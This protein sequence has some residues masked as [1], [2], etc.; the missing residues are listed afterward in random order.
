[1]CIKTC[2]DCIL[3]WSGGLY[4]LKDH[5]VPCYLNSSSEHSMPSSVSL[6]PPPPPSEE[7]VA[8]LFVNQP[9]CLFRLFLSCLRSHSQ[10]DPHAIGG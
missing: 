2:H 6:P 1:M 5:P 10:P 8:G 3:L 9:H 4:C 7:E